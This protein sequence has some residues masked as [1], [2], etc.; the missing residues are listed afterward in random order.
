[1]STITPFQISFSLLHFANVQFIRFQSPHKS[2]S[3][4]SNTG[5]QGTR[6]QPRVNSYLKDKIW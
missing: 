6:A 5:M 4:I 2:V 3:P 1:M